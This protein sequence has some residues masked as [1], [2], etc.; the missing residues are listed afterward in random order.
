MYKPMPIGVYIN[1]KSIYF[2]NSTSILQHKIIIE[3]CENTLDF[4]LAGGGKVY[5]DINERIRFIMSS[6]KKELNP[7]EKALKRNK[8][9]TLIS[10]LV[11]VV[12]TIVSLFVFVM[13]PDNPNGDDMGMLILLLA[14]GLPTL[15]FWVLTIGLPT[16]ERKR[17]KRSFCPNCGEKYNYQND[18][19]WEVS[20]V[21]TNDKKQVA[22]VEFEC[23]CHECG[24]TTEFAEKFV[25]ATIDEN[26]KIRNNNIQDQAKKYFIK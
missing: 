13:Q 12:L 6:V 25:T 21:E 4:F 17:I 7:R 23:T 24:H 10:L 3:K 16:Y 22:R 26:G 8:K 15:F 2:I 9:Q 20:D 11:S 18:V 14:L 1:I 19:S 5:L